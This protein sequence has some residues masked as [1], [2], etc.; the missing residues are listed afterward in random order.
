MLL[1]VLLVLF[2]VPLHPSVPSQP[3]RLTP[4]C[5]GSLPPCR[6]CSWTRRASWSCSWSWSSC[7]W[8]GQCCWS[9]SVQQGQPSATCPAS[10]RASKPSSRCCWRGCTS[11]EYGTGAL[12][13][14]GTESAEASFCLGAAGNAEEVMRAFYEPRLAVSLQL[15]HTELYCLALLFHH[16]YKLLFSDRIFHG[17]RLAQKSASS[18]PCSE[19][20]PGSPKT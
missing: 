12:L 14:L 17:A 6:Q 8:W 4:F 18:C 2:P 1:I 20:G 11:R 13:A 16:L 10:L 5:A 7:W 19:F 3:C 9:P 15:A